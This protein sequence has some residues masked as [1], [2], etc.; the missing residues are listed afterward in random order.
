MLHPHQLT[1]QRLAAVMS[2]ELTASPRVA[3][4]YTLDF[5]ALPRI[6]EAFLRLLEQEDSF[7]KLLQPIAV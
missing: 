5:N 4:D 3:S 7:K 2:E 1:P 6:T